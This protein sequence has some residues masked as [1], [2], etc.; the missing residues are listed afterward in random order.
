MHV[1]GALAPPLEQREIADAVPSGAPGLACQDRTQRAIELARLDDPVAIEVDAAPAAL[2]H[3][4][5]GMRDGAA[6]P[7]GVS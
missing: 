2:E 6:A 1:P 7:V 5:E 4:H 3:F